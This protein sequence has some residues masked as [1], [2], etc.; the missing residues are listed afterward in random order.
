MLAASCEIA[1][2][3]LRRWSLARGSRLHSRCALRHQAEKSM[4]GILPAEDA[5]ELSG[6]CGSD[7]LQYVRVVSRLAVAVSVGT[8]TEVS[9]DIAIQ[10]YR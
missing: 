7:G 9:H 6:R 3:F 10:K 8:S 4:A 1:T 5:G 2:T